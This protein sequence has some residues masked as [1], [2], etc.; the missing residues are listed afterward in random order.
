MS[1]LAVEAEGKAWLFTLGPAGGSSAGGV[2][3]AEVGP[4]PPATRSISF[5]LTKLVAHRAA[6]RRYTVTLATKPTWCWQGSRAFV[7]PMG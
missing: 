6:R 7:A 1:A 2:K 4:I 5:G 3:V